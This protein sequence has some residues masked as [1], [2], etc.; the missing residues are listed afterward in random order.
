MKRVTSTSTIDSILF[1]RSISSKQECIDL[2]C[3][4]VGKHMF[5]SSEKIAEVEERHDENSETVTLFSDFYVCSSDEYR[6]II[7]LLIDLKLE[8]CPATRAKVTLLLNKI[9]D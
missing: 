1:L 7:G 9:A 2:Y 5:S 8:V 6:E 3:S 4:T